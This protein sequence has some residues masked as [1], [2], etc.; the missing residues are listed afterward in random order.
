MSRVKRDNSPEQMRAWLDSI[1]L[2]TDPPTADALFEA[3]TIIG[4]EVLHA[5]E[6]EDPAL[7][8]NLRKAYV[9]LAGL[10]EPEQLP[11]APIEDQPRG[12]RV[13]EDPD[14]LGYFTDEA[15][16]HRVDRPG[17]VICGGSGVR[18]CEFGADR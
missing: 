10:Q 6:N 12:R 4:V 7:G 2:V 18:C 14:N 15:M 17:C 1:P 5:F 11:P 13:Y 16:A 3:R 8:E 9:L